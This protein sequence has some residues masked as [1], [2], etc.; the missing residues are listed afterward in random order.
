MLALFSKHST[1]FVRV[2]PAY[3]YSPYHVV[4]V[5]AGQGVYCFYDF[6]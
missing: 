4:C 2:A 3:V 1:V 5:Q 6:V